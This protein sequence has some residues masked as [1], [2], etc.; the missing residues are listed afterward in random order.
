V[1][2]AFTRRRHPYVEAKDYQSK[3]KELTDFFAQARR[4]MDAREKNPASPRDTRYEAMIP[5]LKGQQP[6]FI[7]VQSGLDIQK[8]VQFGKEQKVNFALV[9]ATDAPKTAAFLKENGVPVILGLPGPPPIRE[10]DPADGV[11]RAAA[12]LHEQGVRFAFG[13][14]QQTDV[15]NLRHEVG[16]AVGCGLPQ[17]VALRSVTLTPAEIVGVADKIGSIEKGKRANLVLT[18]GDIFEYGTHIVQTF[19]NG[20]PTGVRTRYIDLAEQYKDRR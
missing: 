3:M 2:P 19:V 5:V 13:S 17:D 14:D 12:T 20:V 15:R 7:D 9:G 10:D 18:D 8:A 1:P 11:C 16:L 6:V 4:Y